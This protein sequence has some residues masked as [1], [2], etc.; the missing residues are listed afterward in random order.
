MNNNNEQDLLDA[1]IRTHYE[2]LPPSEKSLADLLLSFPGNITDYSA[3]EL[4]KQA[5]TSKAIATRFFSRLGYKD[6]NDARRQTREAKKWGAPI[7]QSSR[8]DEVSKSESSN[9]EIIANHINREQTNLQR[10]LEGID[11]STLRSLV[12]AIISKQRVLIVGYRNNRF[13]AEYLHRQLGL[14][15]NNVTLHPGP[16]Q[17]I[18]EEI[19][20]INEDDLLIVFAMRRRTPILD[21]VI[22]LA[23]QK[24]TPIALIADPTAATLEKRAKWKL[25]CI[26][27]GTSSFDSY[28]SVISVLTLL[29]SIVCTESTSALERLRMVESTH[30]NL[31][32]LSGK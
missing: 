13:L 10:T 8:F 9:S 12:K 4:C 25:N 30:D 20:D 6:F 3:T 19:F 5:K 26:V 18:A 23:E 22:E 32:E 11:I 7:Y 14:L 28:S 15:R 1:R 24:K 27:H 16:N 21:K 31:G 29:I 17:A 2:S